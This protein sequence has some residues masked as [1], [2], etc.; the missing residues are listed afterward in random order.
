MNTRTAPAPATPAIDNR[1]LLAAIGA[2]IIW[3]LLPLFIKLL[4]NVPVLQLT[5]HRLTWGCLFGLG[6]LALRGELGHVWAALAN[7]KVRWRLCAS[8]ALIS[9]NWITYV[10]GIATHRVVETSLGYFINP[11]VNVTIGVLVLSERLNNTQW[12]SVA[13]AAGGV[14][15]LAWASG[16]LPWISLT[17][18]CSFALYGQCASWCRWMP[19]P[20]SPPK[21]SSC[22]RWASATWSGARSRV[23]A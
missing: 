19:W 18:A 7:P 5:A 14:S 23:P 4:P 15:Y 8:V 11:L 3:G 6:W 16:H 21:R 22:C 17:L 9:L 12:A 10:Y 1:G 13:L 2:F 20:A